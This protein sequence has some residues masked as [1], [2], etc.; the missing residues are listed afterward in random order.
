[1]ANQETIVA[2]ATATGNGAI[3][4]IRVS[5]TDAIAIGNRVF[6]GKDLLQQ[7]SHTLHFG[8]IRDGDEAMDEVLD[9][10]FV[11]RNSFTGEDSVEL[12]RHKSRYI[13]LRVIQLLIKI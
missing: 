10:L 3:A 5:G 7:P 9:S 1:M 8:T 11:G 12:S 13:I 2:L 6:K 4:I